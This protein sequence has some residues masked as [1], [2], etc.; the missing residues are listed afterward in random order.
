MVMVSMVSSVLGVHSE[1][2]VPAWEMLRFMAAHPYGLKCLFNEDKQIHPDTLVVKLI[3]GEEGIMSH[4][5]LKQVG[6]NCATSLLRVFLRSL[7]VQRARIVIYEQ[8]FKPSAL[9]CDRPRG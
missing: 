4:L 5:I 2:A 3:D 7:A 6:A 1:E 9:C 8:R